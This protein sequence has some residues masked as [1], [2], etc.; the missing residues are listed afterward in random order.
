MQGNYKL[1][2]LRKDLFTKERKI[3]FTFRNVVG[4]LFL[5]QFHFSSEIWFTRKSTWHFFHH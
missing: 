4:I 1:Q 5:L 2:M 3:N